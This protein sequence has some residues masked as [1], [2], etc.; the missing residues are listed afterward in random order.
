MRLQ[1]LRAAGR[2][3]APWKNGGGTTSEVAAFPPGAAL[4]EFDWRVSVAEVAASGPFSAFP[5]VDR[6]LTVLSGDGLELRIAEN[7][8]TT[9]GETSAPFSFPG[10]VSVMAPLQR[11]PIPDLNAMTRRD[12]WTHAVERLHLTEGKVLPADGLLL[13]FARTPVEIAT[14]AGPV[15]LEPHDAVLVDDQPLDIW[16]PSGQLADVVLIRLRPA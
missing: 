4:G 13:A 9:L 2:I 16:P 3:A 5:G 14:R 8:P 7:D 11:G 6:T 1:V 15:R 12:R 10:D